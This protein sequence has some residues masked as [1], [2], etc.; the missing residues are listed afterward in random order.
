MWMA[1]GTAAQT[2][3]TQGENQKV[4]RGKTFHL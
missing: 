4:R 3:T 1:K 2:A